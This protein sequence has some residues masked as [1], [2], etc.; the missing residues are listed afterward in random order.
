MQGTITQVIALTIWGNAALRESVFLDGVSFYPSNSTFV[1]CEYVKF[2]DLRG[3]GTTWKQTPYA[4]DPI[5]WF[6]RIKHEGTYTL[7]MVYEPS[8]GEAVGNQKI[9]ERLLVGFVGGGGHWLI[10]AVKPTVSDYWEARWEVGDRN[11]N[12]QKIWRV[13]YGRTV[14]DGPSLQSGASVSAEEIKEQLI[15]HL[16]KIAEFARVHNEEGFAKAFDSALT[17]LVSSHPLEGLYH[18]DI[19]PQN[20]LSEVSEQ[21][22]GA[23]Q[24]AWVFGGMGSWND[25]EF[26][27][28][29][30]VQYEVLSEELYRLLNA[31]IVVAANSSS[32]GASIAPSETRW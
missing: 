22:L 19:A 12:D 16:P 2:V 25:M 9:P 30:Q 3:Q 8:K 32:L 18:A 7:R 10:E 14:A 5:N 28:E 26:D 29:D 4:D 31:A 27:G 13:T 11:R 24:A 21:I 1:F 20:F 17:R 6:R 23:A 15:A